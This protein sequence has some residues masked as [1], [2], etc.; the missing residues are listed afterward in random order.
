MKLID[1]FEKQTLIYRK[2]GVDLRSC[3]TALPK[4]TT[5][6]R[7][8]N[9]YP[10]VIVLPFQTF[11]INA[12]LSLVE[13]HKGGPKNVNFLDPAKFE[14]TKQFP[15]FGQ[16]YVL[17]DVFLFTEC[18]GMT[19]KEARHHL[20]QKDVQRPTMEQVLGFLIAYPDTLRKPGI[21][22]LMALDTTHEGN[23]VDL[24]RFADRLKT[25]REPEGPVGDPEWTTIGYRRIQHLFP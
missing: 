1:E 3:R 21:R 9:H 15:L 24:Y 22:G 6:R 23:D 17:I 14:D 20:K 16:P 18:G 12:L 8:I 19:P 5:V 2:L 11:N 4:G 10:I 25:K 7:G 13:L